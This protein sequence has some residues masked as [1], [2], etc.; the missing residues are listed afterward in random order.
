MLPVVRFAVERRLAAGA[1]DYWDLATLLELDVLDGRPDDARKW[2]DR[3]LAG[4]REPWEAG[5]TAGNLTYI[6]DARRARGQ[7]DQWLA[8]AIEVLRARATA[9]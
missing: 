4:V 8:E 3:A 5:T 2:L 9:G 7:H 6:H 1:P